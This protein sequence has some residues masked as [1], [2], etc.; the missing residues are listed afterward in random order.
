M[1]RKSRNDDLLAGMRAANPFSATELREAITDAELSRAMQRA[2]AVGESPSQPI[3]AGDRV[4]CEHAVRTR[5]ARRGVF[6]RHRG[7]SLGLGLSGLACVVAVAALILLSGGSVDSVRD[8]AHPTFA[9][10]AV[11]VAEANPRLLV[12]AP[13]WSIVHARGFEVDSGELI[14][15]DGEHRPYGPGGRQLDL[16]W[17]PASFYRERLREDGDVST[18]AGRVTAPVTSTLL[19][20]RATTFH[21]AGQ[22]PNYATILSPQGNVFIEVHGTLGSKQE[23]EAVLHSLRPVGVDAWLGAMPPE[24]VRPAVRP[25]AIAQMLRAIPVP[26]GFDTSALQS[27]SALTDRFMLGKSVTGAV[28]CDWLQRWLSATRAGDGATAQEAVDA[29]GTARH[30]PV[31]LQMVRERGYRGNVLPPHGRGWPSEILTAAREI[32]SG[33]LRR[34]PAVTTVYVHGLP[35]GYMTPAG[36][37]PASVMG[38][39]TSPGS[40]RR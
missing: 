9:A 37:A 11:E 25:E 33:H 1:T 18:R 34:R 19:G 4:A 3:P 38:C 8:G 28:A 39:L 40:S 22:R 31:L 30:W 35:A 29:M 17:Y 21:Y 15:G 32:A 20:Q 7:A 23:Y 27:E 10:A 13:G 6:S 14:Y 24:V 16:T 36:A 2:I 5:S 26:P 12:T